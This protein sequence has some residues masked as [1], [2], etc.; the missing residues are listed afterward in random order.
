[1]Q[2]NK[3]S[4]RIG[5]LVG[6][7][8]VD[9]S[10]AETLLEETARGLGLTHGEIP[11]T[12]RSGLESGIAKPRAF[13][14]PPP[15]KA[16]DPEIRVA[17]PTEEPE[18]EFPMSVFPEILQAFIGEIAGCQQSPRDFVGT[19]ILAA[20][21]IAIGA[22]HE[23]KVKDGWWERPNLY[24]AMVGKTGTHKSPSMKTVFKPIRKMQEVDIEAFTADHANYEREKAD[25]EDAEKAR[26][27][28]PV[29]G[30]GLPKPEEPI[31]KRLYSTDAT[32][33]SLQDLL[34]DNPRGMGLMLDELA[35][36]ITGLN[37]YKGGKGNDRQFY[38][39]AWSGETYAI[40]RKRNLNK[41]PITCKAP[42]LSI[43]GG[44]Q[45]SKLPLFVEE[46]NE[47]DGFVERILFCYPP[48]TDLPEWSEGRI[49]PYLEDAWQAGLERLYAIP[50]EH[51][52]GGL[53]SR[54]LHLQGPAKDIFIEWNNLLVR[55]M[56]S[57]DANPV[58]RGQ[59]IKLRSYFARFTLIIHLLRASFDN[60]DEREIDGQS[61]WAAAALCD[62]F[63]ANGAKAFDQ[64][65]GDSA[66]RKAIHLFKWI[67]QRGG[68]TTSAEV[69]QNR[70]AGVETATKAREALNELEERGWGKC[71]LTGKRTV[72]FTAHSEASS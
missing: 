23:I 68:K 5:Q 39:K 67:K 63:R 7:G 30:E 59:Q 18:I 41:R 31:C 52:E 58:L 44:I 45:P 66:R 69:L 9:R 38:L 33:E 71:E 62:Y 12:I 37:Q 10:Q 64:F 26:R 42:C 51:H 24:T 6:Q 34:A 55:D 2:L 60:T 16:D 13:Y 50:L 4:F 14:P 29:D 1:M 22:S 35:A 70:V 46:G 65:V 21:G 61:A 49:D 25:W 57:P 47:A 40:D 48:E 32:T 53:R 27:K 17:P 54:T 20:A 56:N 15:F 43:V 11:K 8:H 36:W 72:T 3:S 19:A 28:K